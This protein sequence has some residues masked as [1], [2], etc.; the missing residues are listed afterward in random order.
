VIEEQALKKL[1]GSTPLQEA[2][3]K[4]KQDGKPMLDLFVEQLGEQMRARVRPG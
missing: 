4:F 3:G 2:Y 1:R